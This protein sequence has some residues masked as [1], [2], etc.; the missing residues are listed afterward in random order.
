MY[1]T[2][3]LMMFAAFALLSNVYVFSLRYSRES[4][5]SDFGWYRKFPIALRFFDSGEG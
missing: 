4:T 5:I 1:P 3:I 2:L